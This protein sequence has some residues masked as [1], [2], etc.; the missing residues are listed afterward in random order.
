MVVNILK[1]DLKRKKVM[2]GILFSFITLCTVFLASSLSNLMM[3]TRALDYFATESQISDYFIFA[4]NDELT[5]WLEDHENVTTF[6]V[7]Q[8]IS[9]SNERVFIES[10][11]QQRLMTGSGEGIG[12]DLTLTRLPER[13]ILPLD[14]NNEPPQLIGT[15]EIALAFSEANHHDIVL[16]DHVQIEIGDVIYTFEVTQIVKDIMFMPRLF[17]SDEDFNE[18]SEHSTNTLY[19]YAINVDDLEAFTSSL[20]RA[21]FTSLIRRAEAG[22]FMNM[23]MVDLMSMIILV[24]AGG[25]LIVISLV[26]LRFAIVFT[27]QEDYKEI[28][29]MKAIGLKDKD[30][31]NVYLVK[32]FFLAISGATLGVGLSGPFSSWLMEEL[33]ERIAFP[34]AQAM[35][36]IRVISGLFIVGLILLFCNLSTNKVKKFTAMTAIRSGETGERFK[37]KNTMYLHRRK[38]L[39]AVMYLVFNDLLSNM[40]SYVMLLLIFTSGFIGAVM[41]LNASNTLVPETFA[42][43]IN[44]PP[45][46]VY[47]NHVSFETSPFEGT[48]NDLSNELADLADFYDGRGIELDWQAKI[49]FDG[50]VYVNDVYDGVSISGITQIISL[51]DAR[52]ESIEAMRGVP[53]VLANEMAATENLLTRFG[54]DIGDEINLSVG[55]VSHRFLITGTYETLFYFGTGVRLSEEVRL[56]D[57][58]MFNVYTILGNFVDQNDVAGQMEQLEEISGEGVFISVD[59]FI[60]QNMMDVSI[61]DT[62][63]GLLLVVIIFVN[64]LI[65]TLMSVSFMLKDLKQMALLKSLGF[66]NWSLRLWQGS[67]ILV[68]MVISLVLAILLVPGANLIASIPFGIMGTPS[69]RLNVDAM[70]VYVWYPM[71]FIGVTVLT[72]MVTTLAVKKVGLRDLGG[73]D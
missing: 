19:G 70:N 38:G 27:L 63:S 30:I 11:G 55:G 23:F 29:I 68:V 41:P 43:L 37:R 48:V 9:L 50:I 28:G 60:E 53:P 36:W 51:E 73:A 65:I 62:I 13:L 54:V 2:N 33:R 49:I 39:P 25:V 72:L 64:V 17:I 5:D 45:S 7:S 34:D 18:L 58:A 46:D 66:S 12:G 15:G 3:T 44:V 52:D 1:K 61:V 67:R 40:K 69:L 22:L 20:N 14:V 59:E 6:E 8:L 71:I 21:S 47:L 4:T 56:H 32:Y 24:L 35:I 31:K 26:V 42:Q 57:E 10:E 16:G